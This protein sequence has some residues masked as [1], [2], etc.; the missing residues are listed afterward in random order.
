MLR[1][2]EESSAEV[3]DEEVYFDTAELLLNS[4]ASV[5]ATDNYDWTPLHAA[6]H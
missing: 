5:N 1:L 3:V 6:A 2:H 4:D